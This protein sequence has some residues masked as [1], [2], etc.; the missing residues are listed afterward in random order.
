MSEWIDVTIPLEAGISVWPGDPPFCAQRIATME[1]DG[2][3]VTAISLSAHTGTHVDAPLHYLAGGAAV[4][5]LPLVNLIGPAQ[6]VRPADLGALV[7]PRVLVR[8]R[9]DGPPWWRQ[10]ASGA[11]LSLEQAR[12]LVAQG[13]LLAGIDALSIGPEGE[14]GEQVHR[15][16]LG[17]GVVIVE[18]L[19]LRETPPGLYEMICLPLKLAGADGAPARVLLR[20]R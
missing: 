18:G 12:R 1:R 2:V 11:G 7:A 6:V 8:T 10:D 13:V 20:R 14:Q 5:R 19:D 16:L 9:E 17:A 4:D 3:N 15:I